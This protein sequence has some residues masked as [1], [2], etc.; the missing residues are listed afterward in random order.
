MKSCDEP[1]YF[2]DKETPKVASNYVCLA[3]LI[4]FVLKNIKTIISI[5]F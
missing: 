4:D 5:C 2:H 3:V 1:I